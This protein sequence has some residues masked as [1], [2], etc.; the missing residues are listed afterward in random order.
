MIDLAAFGPPRSLADLMGHER[1]AV[2]GTSGSAA[3]VEAL[4]ADHGR[5]VALYFDNNRAKHGSEFRGVR[6]APAAEASAFARS[7]S[8]III[9]AAYQVEIAH[10]LIEDLGI[11][12]GRVFP[13]VS[14]MFAGH[15][16]RRAIEPHLER[17]EALLPHLADEA[18]RAY[19]R[20]LV[21]FRWT[22]APLA[23]ERNP[24]LAG[25][26]HYDAPGLAPLPGDH[27]VDC[28]AF[29]GD[30]AK[31]FLERLKGD[32]TVTAIEPLARNYAAMAN[33]IESAGANVM[34][35]RA[36]VGAEPGEAVIAACE[37]PADPRAHLGAGAG[38]TA[39]VETLDR[40]FAGRYGRVSY[41]K[42]DIEGFELAAL[43]GA[44]ALIREA[45]PKL[46]IAG[47]HVPSHL[48]E[49]PEALD[50]IR[51]GYRIYVG[52]HPSAPYE[53]EFFCA[54]DTRAVAA[55]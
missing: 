31:V 39:P 24:K 55:A 38:E 52:H 1:I 46:A 22:M 42:I 23:L 28:G 32:A 20:A 41:I 54:S 12:E 14:R 27:I 44:R 53:C 48:W 34:P 50:A 17:I 15:F 10:Q 36:A 49:I 3:E 18:S 47:Y 43:A 13:F 45:M 11:D 9:A 37:D 5:S 33:W 25:F 4:L 21:R 7:G 51:P 40:L 16:G 19:V 35:V 8:A 29:T 2:F 30:T 26:Y 6:V